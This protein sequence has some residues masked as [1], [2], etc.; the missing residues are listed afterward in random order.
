MG[1]SVPG[2][3]QAR[4]LEWVAISF[5]EDLPNPGIEPT[6]AVLAGRFFTAEP[7][8]KPLLFL[9]V[10]RSFVGGRAGVGSFSLLAFLVVRNSTFGDPN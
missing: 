1:F 7:P 8:G 9:F 4:I 2:M 10:T 6:S 5:S 3:S